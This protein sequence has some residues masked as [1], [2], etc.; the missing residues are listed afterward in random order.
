MIFDPMDGP[1]GPLQGHLDDAR[2]ASVASG[3]D[4]DADEKLHLASCR[5]CSAVYAELVR[6]RA[7]LLLDR[8]TAPVQVL[9]DGHAYIAARSRSA[10]PVQTAGIPGQPPVSASQ[11]SRRAWWALPHGLAVAAVL[12]FTVLST[13]FHDAVPSAELPE[14]VRQA[15]IE[16]SAHG[17]W[18]PLVAD[19]EYFEGPALRGPGTPR[20]GLDEALDELQAGLQADPNSPRRHE[21][22]IAGFQAADQPRNAREYLNVALEMYP[23]DVGLRALEVVQNYREGHLSEAESGLRARLL[24]HPGDELATLDLAIL[25]QGRGDEEGRLEAAQLARELRNRL[26]DSGMGRRAQQLLQ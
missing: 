25:L 22:L 17:M 3:F 18:H 8:F 20:E 10:A 2:L 15:L 4:P 11:H 21:A 6:V 7:E 9:R 5:T 14:T 16:D 26:G 13:H 12:L 19:A 23:S 1:E 24:A